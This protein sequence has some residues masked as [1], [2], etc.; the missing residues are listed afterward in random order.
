MSDGLRSVAPDA[1]PQPPAAGRRIY[2]CTDF[3]KKESKKKR[4]CSEAG[5][6][7]ERPGQDEDYLLGSVDEEE[8]EKA[9]N[10]TKKDGTCFVCVSTGKGS[11]KRRL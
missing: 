1:P 11:G 8:K 6:K 2:D 3:Q 4:E 10:A 7:Y 5:V 9:H